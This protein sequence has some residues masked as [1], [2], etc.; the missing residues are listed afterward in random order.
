MGYREDLESIKG[1]K[2]QD[3]EGN[4]YRMRFRMRVR[5]SLRR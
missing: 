1:A 3:I 4:R 5:S 2:K